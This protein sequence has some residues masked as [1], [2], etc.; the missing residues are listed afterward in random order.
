[1]IR[2]LIINESVDLG[3]INTNYHIKN[4][5]SPTIK[6]GCACFKIED[7]EYGDIEFD[8]R[9]NGFFTVTNDG[10]TIYVFETEDEM[11]AFGDWIDNADYDDIVK[12]MSGNFG[13]ISKELVNEYNIIGYYITK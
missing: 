7:S 8:L 12:H 9:E 5:T 1:M 6:T 2:K 3:E 10:T 11:N 13:M 4:L